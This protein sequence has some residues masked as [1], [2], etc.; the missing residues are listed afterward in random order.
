MKALNVQ[1]DG[2]SFQKQVLSTDNDDE[3]QPEIEDKEAQVPKDSIWE[4]HFEDT[5]K[6]TTVTIIEDFDQRGLENAETIPKPKSS[7][8][9]VPPPSSSKTSTRLDPKKKKAFRYGTK[10]ERQSDRRKAQLKRL[11]KSHQKRK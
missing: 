10:A 9:E 1:L 7:K 8:P 5:E 11:N 4:N 6:M 3:E 2:S